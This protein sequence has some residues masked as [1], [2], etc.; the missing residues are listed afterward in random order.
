[1]A[2]HTPN[3]PQPE[4]HWT[5]RDVENQPPRDEVLSLRRLVQESRAR[6]GPGA[7]IDRVRTDLSDRGIELSRRDIVSVWD[8]CT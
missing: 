4:S 6:L 7:D 5:S 3:A 1:M 2:E 8:E